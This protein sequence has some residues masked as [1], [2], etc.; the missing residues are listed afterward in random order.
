MDVILRS[1]EMSYAIWTWSVWT[2][3]S[4]ATGGRN[5]L[6]STVEGWGSSPNEKKK[7]LQHL[8]FFP[9]FFSNS[10]ADRATKIK[11]CFIHRKIKI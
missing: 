5:V 4:K 2:F 10:K 7:K 6:L 8:G 9:S 11:L 1:M 3:H